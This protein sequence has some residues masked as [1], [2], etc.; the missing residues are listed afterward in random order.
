MKKPSYV[1]K[2]MR[3]P[4]CGQD[5]PHCALDV[6]RKC[7]ISCR[8][9][10]NNGEDSFKS[11]EELE[12]ELNIAL[13]Q[14]K[15]QSVLLV[16][17]EP[18]LHPQIYEIIKMIRRYGLHVE[19]SSNA[20]TLYEESAAKL[21]DA[22]LSFMSIHIESQQKRPDLP[23]NSTREERN[24]LRK[25]KAQ[26]LAKYNIEPALIITAF[27]DNPG[28]VEECM[29]LFLQSNIFTYFLIT[30]YRDTQ[31]MGNMM[32]EMNVNIISDNH[33]YAEHK[34]SFNMQEAEEI[35]G[36]YFNHAPFNFMGSNVDKNDP[37]WLSYRVFSACDENGVVENI[38]LEPTVFEWLYIRLYKLIKGTYIFYL[39]PS[40]R[41]NK[42]QVF[43]NGIFGN[44][45]NIPFL[46]RNIKRKFLSKIFLIQVCSETKNGVLVR[47]AV[48]IDAQVKSGQLVPTCIGDNIK[49]LS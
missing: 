47:C 18:L 49:K 11:L 28:E 26:L 23:F 15:L 40:S 2:A 17:G 5:I 7:N 14:R 46:I 27:K 6:C 29:E 24:N 31:A 4:W 22:G 42:L 30:L 3:L 39:P 38:V 25:Q 16:G 12:K 19:M 34:N 8:A 21:S 44:F 32:G 13:T 10:Y 20:L 37:R 33:S 1:K 43:F 41:K 45:K 35:V 9:C 36:K 48:C